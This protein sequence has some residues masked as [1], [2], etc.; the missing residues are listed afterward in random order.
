LRGIDGSVVFVEVKHH[1]RWRAG[2]VNAASVFPVSH[3]RG[4]RPIPSVPP[5]GPVDSPE[6]RTFCESLVT[7][8][9]LRRGV[10]VRPPLWARAGWC[11]DNV[12]RAIADWGGRSEPGWRIIETLPTVLLEAEFHMLWISPDEEA[13]DVTPALVRGVPFPFLPDPRLRYEGRQIDNR[14]LAL[15]DDPMIDQLITMSER[16]FAQM[17]AGGLAEFHGELPL[18]PEMLADERELIGVE[19]E[20]RRRYHPVPPPPPRRK[21]REGNGR[22]R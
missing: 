20:L 17:N 12:D 8:G 2:V 1:G 13:I 3:P 10:P 6:L 7:T 21:R 18:T 22:R 15:R 5:R 14:R 9:V 16:R 4:K 19:I 11:T